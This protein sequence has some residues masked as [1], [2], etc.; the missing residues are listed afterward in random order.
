MFDIPIG[1]RKQSFYNSCKLVYEHFENVLES[2]NGGRLSLSVSNDRDIYVNCYY[3]ETL[4]ATC[5]Y[6]VTVY[7]KIECSDY[8]GQNRQ[9]Y[10]TIG[11]PASLAIGN[12]VAYYVQNNPTR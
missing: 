3:R 9:V 4:P 7:K 1:H 2:Y 5:N 10:K 11:E 8:F 12:D 6:F